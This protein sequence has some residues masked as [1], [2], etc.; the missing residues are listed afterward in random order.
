[1]TQNRDFFDRFPEPA[2]LLRNGCRTR[3][4][5]G[6]RVLLQKPP[7]AAK[8]GRGRG[9]SEQSSAH[10][11]FVRVAKKRERRQTLGSP[12]TSRHLGFESAA[13]RRNS[14]LRHTLLPVSQLIPCSVK[15]SARLVR[16]A[17]LAK[18]AP[19]AV[20]SS[21]S[22]FDLLYTSHARWPLPPPSTTTTSSIHPSTPSH[23]SISVL[24]SSFNPPHAAHLALAQHGTF[25]A[26]LLVLSTH[27][28]DKGSA[29]TREI[30][31]RLEMM[32]EMA[33]AMEEGGGSNVAVACI[34]EPAFVNKSRVLK[35]A[36]EDLLDEG[37]AEPPP[38]VQLTFLLGTNALHLELRDAPVS[39]QT[40]SRRA[41]FECNR[42]GH[43]HA[44]LLPAVLPTSFSSAL[45]LS[46]FLLRHRLLLDPLR[47]SRLRRPFARGRVGFPRIGARQTVG[48][49]RASRT[50]RFGPEREGG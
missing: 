44:V 1:M 24:D 7:S 50:S 12:S 31:L 15:L 16:R 17:P 29:E 33:R 43:T 18:M 36:L 48:R 39:N 38:G 30:A 47:P 4:R 20:A 2:K 21:S 10:L 22:P 27:N 46:H 42:L 28:A 13:A 11:G 9:G 26:R 32:R 3:L 45:R 8:Q 5:R 14:D 19:R 23:L 37:G 34:H 25:D 40:I 6:Q 41:R 35:R 49:T